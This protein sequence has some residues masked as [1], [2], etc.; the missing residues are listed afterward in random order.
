M[1]VTLLGTGDTTGTPTVG[2][3]CETCRAARDRGISRSRFSVHLQHEETGES[4]LIDFSPDFRQQ[5]LEND[6]PLPE[7]GIVTHI[8]FDH[9]DGLGNV[10]RVLDALTVHAP[11]EVDPVTDESVAGTI[12]KKFHYLEDRIGVAA[13]D[14][15]EPFETCGFEIQFVPVD[16]PPLQC[17]GLTI[18]EPETGVKLSMTGDTSYDI[19]DRSREVLANPDML[20][21]DAIVPASLCDR[22]PIGGRHDRPDGTP[23]TFGTKHMTRE[24]AL[25]L[26][27]ELSAD[28]TRLV[29][30]AH[31][32]P[33]EEAFEEPLA[34]D[35]ERYHLR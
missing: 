9:L 18:E 8:H 21:A 33:A 6:V 4:L 3:A 24:G 13:H 26:A 25:D 12:R 1:Q 23:R 28:R 29:H 15:F 27:A 2:C 10:Y 14:P 11:G 20:L 35:G 34:I 16:H 7:A 5:F 17:Y 30:L 32:Y 19:P 22:H 31:F